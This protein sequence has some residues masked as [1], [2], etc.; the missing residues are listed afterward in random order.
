[1]TWSTFFPLLFTF[2][3]E[4]LNDKTQTMWGC[5][6]WY[7]TIT[8]FVYMSFLVF[9][10][11]REYTFSKRISFRYTLLLGEKLLGFMMNVQNVQLENME[12][13]R[14]ENSALMQLFGMIRVLGRRTMSK[15]ITFPVI[16]STAHYLLILLSPTL[17][18]PMLFF[19]AYFLFVLMFSS[20]LPRST[21]FLVSS[22]IFHK[23]TH[24]I[25]GLTQSFPSEFFS[26]QEQT[27]LGNW[28]DL[29]RI[30]IWIRKQKH[31]KLKS[32]LA[33]KFC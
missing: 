11:S 3:K 29:A 20:F 15:L 30:W 8:K 22:N 6:Y 33:G 17:Y 4:I 21:Y 7:A 2:F 16:I 14:R 23:C 5:R 18:L 10:F 25:F 1:M 28:S 32:R 13:K 9:T 31:N 26:P 27:A 24:H 19:A 12:R